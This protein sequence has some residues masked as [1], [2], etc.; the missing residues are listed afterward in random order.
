MDAAGTGS[1]PWTALDFRGRSDAPDRYAVVCRFVREVVQASTR[2]A[3]RAGKFFGKR[4]DLKR[5]DVRLVDA[6]MGSGVTQEFL[7]RRLGESQ[8]GSLR[9]KVPL[10][11]L[12]GRRIALEPDYF[13]FRSASN[14]YGRLRPRV[15]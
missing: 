14:K 9:L 11:K 13:G 8:P 3:I 15:V 1:S 7:L 4:L 10:D 2:A 5:R 12:S 6:V